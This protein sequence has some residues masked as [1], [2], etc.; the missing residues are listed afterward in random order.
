MAQ[1]V[2]H[3]PFLA[4]AQVKFQAILYGVY[5]GQS[6]SGN[7]SLGT[8]VFPCQCHNANPRY[9]CLIYLRSTVKNLDQLA[10]SLG[11]AL[12]FLL[13]NFGNNLIIDTSSYL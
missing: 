13:R 10:A 9:S 8:S 2:I 3:R 12:L 7:F 1:A 11:I 4:K 6:D 5:G